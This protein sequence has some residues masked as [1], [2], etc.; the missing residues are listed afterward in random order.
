MHVRDEIVVE[1][2]TVTASEIFELMAST[3][4]WASGLPDGYECE[5]CRKD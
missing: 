1:T 4:D 2:T 3:P 5:F